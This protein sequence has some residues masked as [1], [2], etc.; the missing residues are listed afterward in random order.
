LNKAFVI[1]S[2]T[3]EELISRDAKTAE[4]IKPFAVG[5]D[6]LKWNVD[7]KDKW[8]IYSPWH[9]N[10]EQYPAA[11]EHL[12]KWKQDLPARPEFKSGRYNW[13]CMSRYGA[14]YVEAFD[15]VKI[16]SPKVSLRPSFALDSNGCFLGNTAYSFLAQ[17]DAMYLLG[18]LN[19][20][21]FF[22]YAKEVFVEKQN[23]WYEV[24]P[25]GLEAFPVPKYIHVIFAGS[26]PMIESTSR[27]RRL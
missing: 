7:H 16:A 27:G 12:L 1:D 14:D 19:S 13:W 18:L 2:T 25:R 9:L 21:A 22:T 6:I 10:I 3:R 15:D 4:I 11:K 23:G 20:D 5:K 24:Q 8:L 17:K 26:E